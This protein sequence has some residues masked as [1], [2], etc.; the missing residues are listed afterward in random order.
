MQIMDE[1]TH[2]FR[3]ETVVQ[4]SDVA[5]RY[6]DVVSTKN[7]NGWPGTDRRIKVEIR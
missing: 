2:S 1:T 7:V 3:K 6:S 5:L 4:S